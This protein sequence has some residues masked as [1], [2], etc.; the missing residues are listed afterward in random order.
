MTVFPRVLAASTIIPNRALSTP[1]NAN[2]LD[3]W[4]LV[5]VAARTDGGTLGS[6]RRPWSKALGHGHRDWL[7]L[8][9]IDP[10]D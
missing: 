5:A 2:L 7:R 8:W 10:C 4:A 9:R 1:R 6:L 3:D